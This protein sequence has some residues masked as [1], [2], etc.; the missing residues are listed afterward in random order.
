M[1]LDSQRAKSIFL[2]AVDR[3]VEERAAF[4]DEACAGEAELRRRVEQLLEAHDRPDS[5][6]EAPPD[7]G[8]TRDSDPDE[9]RAP[10]SLAEGPGTVIGPYKLLQQI[11]E[12]AMGVVWR[13]TDELLNRPVAVKEL[14]NWVA[15]PP[16]SR[17]NFRFAHVRRLS[18]LHPGLAPVHGED[19]DRGWLAA[20]QCARLADGYRFF[21]R[22]IAAL[23]VVHGRARDLVI[24]PA[25]SP[26]FAHLAHRLRYA[27]PDELR[28]AI[29][30]WRDVAR[31]LWVA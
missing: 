22:L 23:R 31:Q 10:P 9:G 30:A 8:P 12:G 24:P 18:L 13:A 25:D 6:P 28:A 2:A 20:D 15:R 7:A 27:G 21:R 29:A 11:G 19:A 1:A 5:L 3:P 4:L 26:E 16:R 14:R 17:A